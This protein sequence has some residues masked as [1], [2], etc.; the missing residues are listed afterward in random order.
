MTY[1]INDL[2]VDCSSRLITRDGAPL[3]IPM[4]A[5]DC[6]CMLLQNSDRAVG[7]DELIREIWGHEEI[8]DNQ[9]SQLIVLLRR[10]VGDDGM[11]Q[12]MIRTVPGFGY[13]W[14]GPI[15][16]E[17]AESLE[18]EDSILMISPIS[19][20]ANDED[21]TPCQ[22]VSLAGD[23]VGIEEIQGASR[24]FDEIGMQSAIEAEE[25]RELDSTMPFRSAAA[26]FALFVILLFAA[27]STSD[28]DGLNDSRQESLK[29]VWVLPPEIEFDP[30]HAWLPVSLMSIVESRLRVNGIGTVPIENVLS[31]LEFD[32]VQPVEISDHQLLRQFDAQLIVRIQAKKSENSWTVHLNA[33]PSSGLPVDVE[34]SGERLIDAVIAAADELLIGMQYVPSSPGESGDMPRIALREWIRQGNYDRARK[35]IEAMRTED[36]STGEIA[37]IEA[38]LDYSEGRYTQALERIEAAMD[39]SNATLEPELQADA[40]LLRASVRR[41]LSI[42]VDR[43]DLDMAIRLLRQ[44]GSSTELALAIFKRAQFRARL[45]QYDEAS[46]DFMDARVLFEDAGDEIALA[47]IGYELARMKMERA[48]HAEA[49]VQVRHVKDLYQKYRAFSGLARAYQ[50]E[51]FLNSRLLRWADASTSCNAAMELLERVES[52]PQQERVLRRCARVAIETGQLTRADALLNRISGLHQ[53]SEANLKDVLVLGYYRTQLELATGRAER[54]RKALDDLATDFLAVMSRV[55][56]PELQMKSN[57][58]RTLLLHQQARRS[59]AGI[60]RLPTELEPFVKS[61]ETSSGHLAH[62][63]WL[64]ERDHPDTEQALRTALELAERDQFPELI[65]DAADV[66]IQLLLDQGRVQEARTQVD[67]LVAQNPEVMENDYTV[68]LIRLRVAN[69]YGS[70][71]QWQRALQRV[72]ALAGERPIPNQLAVLS[73]SP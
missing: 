50:F 16:E 52:I 51:I 33:T 25:S 18:D 72:E 54:V 47:D 3:T 24:S 43:G 67:L 12:H 41:A 5:F 53:S 58:E 73:Y 59:M 71:K 56:R 26:L 28:E 60:P 61:P 30:E 7:R 38:R 68:A 70:E 40:L 8:S 42:N 35:E 15:V 10:L 9:L 36:R 21:D 39:S 37:L 2:S 1:R 4:R 6:L 64:S 44:S 34:H 22:N 69:A 14:I 57:L 32:G 13:H 66:L 20:E 31:A 23:G 45:E 19:S 48:Q 63:L 62:A 49:L 29:G 11:R 55:D 46:L 27:G 65:V 17:D